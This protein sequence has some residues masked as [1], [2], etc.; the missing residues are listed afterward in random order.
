MIGA[1]RVRTRLALV[2]L[3]AV[4]AACS[5]A[6]KPKPTPL[7]TLKPEIAGRQ[8]WTQRIGD[9]D[10]PLGIAT[11]AGAF[12][13]A[14]G[15]GSVAAFT[16]DGGRELWRG[17]AGGRLAAGVGSD[18]RYAAVVTRDSQLVVLDAGK[19]LWR[20]PLGTRVVTPP[21]VAGER[22]FVLGIDRSVQAFDALDGRK[23]WSQQRPGDPLTL[24]QPGVL[25]AW[26]DTLVVGQGNRLAGL[27][28]LRGALRWE[29]P[30]ATPR[31]TNE[32]ERLADLVG[33]A[34]R[35]G[36]SLCVRGFQS[37]VGCVDAASGTLAWARNVGGTTGVA[38][39]EDHVYAAD[40]NDRI[41]AWKRNGGE[42]AWTSDRLLHRSLSA[43]LA[44]GRTVAFGDF[45][46][47]MHFLDR[48]SGRPLLRLPTDGRPVAAAPVKIGTTFV[49]V[50][51][52]GGV[53]AF[54]PE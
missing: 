1:A 23:L 15:D 49:A 26:K 11:G 44:V 52:G 5:G 20:A 18:G 29:V 8:V 48:D 35:V 40:A 28:P 37:A 22:V 54:R 39:D 41:T 7:E 31:G 50:T 32:V 3:A 51:R 9:V 6:P 43:P 27:D 46:G 4:L 30:V 33:P 14:G 24:L 53:F 45:E 25:T 13:V 17:D 2:L 42:T 38:A 19:P 36:D 12:V 10:F 34:A 16:A 47:W 21:L